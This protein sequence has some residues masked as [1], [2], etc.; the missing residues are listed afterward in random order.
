MVIANKEENRELDVRRLREAGVRVWVTD[1]ETVPEAVAPSSE[2]FDDVLGWDAPGLAGRGP[3]RCGAARCP[4]VTQT[5]AI[6]IWRD[7]WM[8]VGR[9]TFTGDLA[10][11]L[12][13]AN[14]FADSDRPL[15]ARRRPPRSTA[16]GADVVLLPD[17]PYVFT[18]DD[19]PEAFTRTEPGWSAAGCSRGT[20]RRWSLTE[21]RTL[22]SAQA[23]EDQ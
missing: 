14:V 11:R 20:A 17:E 12:G 7:P 16:P 13:W 4:T 3:R 8:V 6:P 15:P 1:I 23:G 19:G 5:V 18:A 10:R 9:D 22:L 2:L 21:A